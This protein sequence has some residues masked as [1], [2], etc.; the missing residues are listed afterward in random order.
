MLRAVQAG[1]PGHGVQA[2]SMHP[3]LPDS[4]LSAVS[5]QTTVPDL[6]LPV[7]AVPAALVPLLKAVTGAPG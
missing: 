3:D 1:V 2:V 7:A 4:D 6:D 5:D